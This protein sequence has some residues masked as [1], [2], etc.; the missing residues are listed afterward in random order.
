MKYI[1]ILFTDSAKFKGKST[2]NLGFV[3]ES[4][5][6]YFYNPRITEYVKFKLLVVFVKFI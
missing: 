2:S 1:F 3:F 6:Q 5:G 4:T